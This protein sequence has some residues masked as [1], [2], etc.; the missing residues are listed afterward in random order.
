MNALDFLKPELLILIP[1]CWGIG[2]VV[3][4]TQIDNKWI[5]LI[6]AVCSVLLAGVWVVGN[7]D[8]TGWQSVLTAAFMGVTQGVAAWLIAWL[9]Y[10]KGIKMIGVAVEA[11][12]GDE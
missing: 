2:M 6:L 1:V 11:Q 10:E 3:K 12:G 8:Y 4:A 7:M 5:P 9:T